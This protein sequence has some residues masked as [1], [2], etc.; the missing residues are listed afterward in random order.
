MKHIRTQDGT[1]FFLIPVSCRVF[2]KLRNRKNRV[3]IKIK[4]EACIRKQNTFIKKQEKK[5]H[6]NANNSVLY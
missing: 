2:I 5:I 3:A 4:L 6:N 1:K